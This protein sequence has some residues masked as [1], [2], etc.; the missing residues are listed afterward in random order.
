MKIKKKDKVKII[1]GKDKGREGVVEK[2]YKKTGKVIV[3]GINLY[4]RHIKKNEKMPQGGVVELP[5]ALDISKVM[6]V[7]PKCGAAVKIGYKVEKNKKFR[8]CKKCQSKI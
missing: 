4:K 3:P 7:C 6:L 2:V 8:V 1:S 5:R